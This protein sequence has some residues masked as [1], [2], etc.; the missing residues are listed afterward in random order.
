MPIL[1]KPLGRHVATAYLRYLSMKTLLY[2]N[3]SAYRPHY[4]CET[5]LLNISDKWLK[6]MDNSGLVD[7]DLSKAFDLVSHDILIARLSKNH[8]GPTAI[9]L[10]EPRQVCSVSGVLSSPASLPQGSILGP[11]P[12]SV[13]MN[14]L[15]LLLKWT[16]MLTIQLFGQVELPQLKYNKL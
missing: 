6:A 11:L 14:D 7:P 1:S 2:K 8:T 12:F 5:A 10:S 15:P 3:Q 9:N 13:Y 16:S 4:S